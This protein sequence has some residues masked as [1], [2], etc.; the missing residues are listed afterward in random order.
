MKE[1]DI[2]RS[3]RKYK[4][5]KVEAHKIDQLLRAAMQAPSAG[6]QQPWEFI[7]IDD[8]SQKLAISKL[9]QYASFAKD[10]PLIIVVLANQS[11]MRFPDYMPQDLGACTQNLMLEA[12]HQGLGTVWLGAYPMEERV[13]Y[14]NEV[15]DL[16]DNVVAYSVILVGYPLNDEDN[17]FNDRFDQK[18]VHYNRYKK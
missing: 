9:S 15:L 4:N 1:I 10:A 5:Q 3:V 2:R 18:R 8:E 13:N 6:N 7:V 17:F 12:V 11:K 14:L 16:S